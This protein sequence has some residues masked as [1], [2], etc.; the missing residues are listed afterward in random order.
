MGFFIYDG[1]RSEDYGIYIEH[2]PKRPMP[3]RKIEK[4]SVPGR[5]GDLII[6]HGCFENVTQTYEIYIRARGCGTTVKA[7][8]VASWLLGSGGYRWLEDSYDPDFMRLAAFTGPLD[9]DNWMLRY[10]RATLQFDCKPQWYLR[11]GLISE[12]HESPFVLINEMQPARPLIRV[13]GTGGTL[14]VGNTLVQINE[15]NEYVDIDSETQNAYKGTQNCN[16]NVYVPEFPVLGKGET[17][18]KWEGGIAKIEITPRW[19]TI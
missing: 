2:C 17:G 5:S 13:Y 16:P 12:T 14:Y 18:I 6:D 7:R 11:S 19:W 15:I 4:V 8:E 9:V 1:K 3:E 10:G